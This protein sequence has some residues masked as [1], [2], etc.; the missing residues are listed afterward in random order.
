MRNK[1]KIFFT[2]CL[3]L[4]MI[5][6]SGCDNED[7]PTP[8]NLSVDISNELLSWD[9]VE[10]ATGYI[11][12]YES[13][14]SSTLM[15][16]QFSLADLA[17]GEY[18]LKVKSLGDSDLDDSSWSEEVVYVKSPETELKFSLINSNT[19]YELVG[20]YSNV[21][22]LVIPDT[23][24]GLPVVSIAEKALS[25]RSSITSITMGENV[26]V[27][28]DRAFYNLTALES[29]YLND[30]LEVIGEAAF[31]SCRALTSVIVPDT[32]YSMSDNAFAYC[33]GLVSVTLS[34]S[35]TELNSSVFIE[36]TSLTSVVVPDGITFIGESAFSGCELLGD[37]KF[38]SGVQYIDTLAFYQCGIVELVIPG[39][40]ETIGSQ[41]FKN[42]ESLTTL[43][44]ETG[45]SVILDY[46]FYNCTSLSYVNI[47]DGLTSIGYDVFSGTKLFENSTDIV[48]AGNWVVGCKNTEITSVELEDG[49]YGVAS[50]AFYGYYYLESVVLPESLV[51][52]DTYAFTT[53]IALTSIT[54]CSNLKNINDY[55]FYGCTS[56]TRVDLPSSIEVI[57]ISAFRNCTSLSGVL[58]DGSTANSQVDNFTNATFTNVKSI[59]TQA[60]YNTAFYTSSA[61]LVYVGNWLVGCN[62]VNVLSATIKEGTIG[63]SN[64]VFYQS[65]IS[66]INLPTTLQYIGK[67]AFY[68]SSLTYIDIPD[69]VES[70]ASYAFYKCSSLIQVNLPSNIETIEEYTFYSCVT[71]NYI[72]MPDTLKYIEKYAFYYCALLSLSIGDG[73][74]SIGDYAFANDLLLSQIY[75]GDSLKYI[76]KNSFSGLVELEEIIIPDTVEYIDER[77]F[78]GNTAL[79]TVVIGDGVVVV[80]DSAFSQ[81][82]S[83]ENVTIGSSVESLGSYVFYYCE[84]LTYINIPSNVKYIGSY[85][86]RKTALESIILPSTLVE[87]GDHALYGLNLTIYTDVT[88]N[89]CGWVTTYNSS[90]LTMIYGCELSDD[91]SY[92]VSFVYDTQNFT[93][94]NSFTLFVV[95]SREG[96][97]CVGFTTDVNSS[98]VQY[99]IDDIND[100][101]MSNELDGLVLYAIWE[102]NEVDD[103]GEDSSVEDFNE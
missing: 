17:A 52:L 33:R 59:G 3:C 42:C 61:D 39:N 44:V 36:C 45:V 41:S 60:F 86:F 11:V 79:T 102:M 16:N 10:N 73:V 89:E 53:A 6:L 24:N 100:D 5:T 84:A 21:I 91:S 34:E 68:E 76:G 71:L 26:E 101:S 4:L 29:L 67:G 98:N 1:M 14:Q 40:I 2:G 90:Y 9:H 94:K 92:L 48:Y 66:L 65:T 103:S 30:G 96:Y 8:T 85:A 99:T 32:V 27:I 55:A 75:L 69:S 93:N 38:G 20:L 7:M 37:V 88:A 57:G 77:A 46:A 18:V 80:G 35:L 22:E 51:I 97:E 72:V 28:N 43:V 13:G 54:M 23:Y 87:I 78:Y 19:A 74:E 82:S 25:G 64:Y 62:S 49:T 58:I 12:D 56:L 63:I 81:C 50:G 47:A 95:P 70:I 15:Y 83:L 31:Q